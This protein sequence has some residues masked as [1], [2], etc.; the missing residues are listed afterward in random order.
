M[1]KNKFSITTPLLIPAMILLIAANLLLGIILMEQS[2]TSMQSLIKARMLDIANT[3]AYM[4]DGDEMKKLQKGDENTPEYQKA[5]NILRSFQDNIELSYIYGVRDEGNDHFSFTID[6][7]VDP[8]EFGEEIAYTTALKAASL[9]TPSVDEVPYE[10][11]WGR[12]Y[13]AYSPIFDSEGKVAGIVAV[14]FSAEWYESRVHKQIISVVLI[15]AASTIVGILMALIVSAK[16]RRRFTVLY[17]EMNDLALDFEDLNK[18]IKKNGDE[19]NPSAPE[20]NSDTP[21]EKKGDEIGELG[22]QLLTFRTE[23]RQYI[24]YVHSQAYIDAMTGAGSKTAYLNK[25]KSIEKQILENKANFAVVVFDINGLKTINDNYGHELGDK[26]ISRAA[27]TI[28]SVFGESNV[29]RIGGDEFI[30]V[31]EHTSVG[32]VR[33]FFERFDRLSDE[34][35]DHNEFPVNFSVSKGSEF[36]SKTRDPDYKTAFKRA[37]EAMYRCKSDHYKQLEQQK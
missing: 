37:D 1:K 2:R 22:K 30:A 26:F 7:D 34:I 4:L 35:N 11:R 32:E 31:L 3:A 18:F 25:V 6:P 27:E 17:D 9:G 8:G 10:D 12:F 21:K 16:I 15:C 23:L 19:K 13:S 33:E 14:D 20:E 29:Y 24:T 5:Q 36:Y 28:M